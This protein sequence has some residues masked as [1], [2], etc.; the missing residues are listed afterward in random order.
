MACWCGWSIDV[1]TDASQKRQLWRT[2]AG[3]GLDLQST[4][5]TLLGQLASDV[6]QIAVG[7]FVTGVGL[8]GLFKKGL[9][10]FELT[11]GGIKHS[12]VVVGL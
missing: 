4:R 8:Q 7:R 9:G 5:I 2:D 1:P 6:R 3:F 12:Q 11:L 10:F